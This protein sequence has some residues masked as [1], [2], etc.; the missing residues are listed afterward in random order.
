MQIFK[1]ATSL[2]LYKAAASLLDVLYIIN[3]V[4]VLEE[5]SCWQ[6]AES[7]WSTLSLASPRE[8]IDMVSWIA[9]CLPSPLP[10]SA[11]ATQP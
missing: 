7:S 1:A 6:G 8:W 5:F 3:K 4:K 10:P 9:P 2:L 11:A